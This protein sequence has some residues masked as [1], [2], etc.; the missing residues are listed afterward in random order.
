MIE[1]IDDADRKAAIARGI[2]E[3]LTDW[4]GVEAS[5]EQYIED[6]RGW[7]FLAD[8]EAGSPVGFLCLKPT[9][10]ATVE[11]AVMGVRREWHRHGCGRR[12]VEAAKEAARA[13][14]YRFMQVKTVKMG[15][16]E[17]YDRTNRFYQSMGFEEFEV[18]PELWG[19]E[20][21]CQ[22]YVL[23]L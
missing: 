2:L 16:Y 11:L 14:G 20:N 9:G 21:P 7:L 10:R 1:R 23:A 6:S 18:M 13:A 3:A 15:M 17:D 4:F 12:L 5:R 19:E 8:I 22:I